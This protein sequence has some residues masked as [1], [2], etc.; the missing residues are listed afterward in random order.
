MSDTEIDL[1]EEQHPQP[2]DDAV[3]AS[4]E[5]DLIIQEKDGVVIEKND[6]SLAEFYRWYE[7]GRLIVDPEWQR[8]YVW[9]RRRASKLIESVLRDIPVPVIYLARNEEGKYEVIDGLQRLTSIFD[10]FNN[11]YHLRGLEL[12]P[13]LNG[14]TFRELP[15]STQSK[16][17]DTTLRTFELSPRTPKDLMFVIFERLNTGGI[18]LNDM[19]IRNCLYRGSLNALL[20]QLA[21]NEDFITCAN[22]RNLGKRMA[23]RALILRF[24][25]FYERTHLKARLG[26]KRFLNEFFQTYRNADDDK[27][28]EYEREFK[29]AMKACVTVFGDNGFRLRRDSASGGGEWATRMNA[30]IFQVVATSF[31]RY[32]LGHITRNA[33]AIHEEY[34]DLVSTDDKWRD[35][36]RRATGETT[37]MEY[38]FETWQ[39]RL[40]LAMSQGEP[41]D[42]VRL[43]SHKLKQEMYDQNQTC[44]LCGQRITLLLDAALDHDLHYWRGGKTVP[45]N[46]RLVHRHCNYSR[47]K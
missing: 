16:I 46:A 19:E 11:D 41:N 24:L 21:L 30:A 1:D 33:D 22:Q 8:Q 29:K 14:K 45:E 18:A 27:L 17:Q 36:T 43:F 13:E 7:N 25:A 28:A 35:C 32:D 44:A 34:V 37:R 3:E 6:R 39:N 12:A 31:S 47:P 2:A 4:D 23:D 20:K 10:F 9:D 5:G 42:S 38:A 40:K 26:L 15:E